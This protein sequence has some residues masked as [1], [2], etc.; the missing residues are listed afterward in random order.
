LY[1]SFYR[2][3]KFFSSPTKINNLPY[4]K[5]GGSIPIFVSQPHFHGADPAYLK[6]FVGGSLAPTADRHSTHMVL[7]KETSIPLE[8]AMRLQIIL[9]VKSIIS[10][11]QVSHEE[12]YSQ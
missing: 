8:V 3:F 7:Q 6:Q 9:Q 2:W 12:N 10:F 11:V 5:G 4:C 1:P